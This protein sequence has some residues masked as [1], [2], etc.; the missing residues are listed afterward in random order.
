[1]IL[2]AI[3][4]LGPQSI[5]IGK[6]EVTV[7]VREKPIQLFTY[8]PKNYRAE[9]MILVFH[10]TLRN[11]D[12]YRDDAVQMAERYRALVVAPT[13]DS[14]RFPNWRY[15]RGGVMDNDFH[16]QPADTWTYGLIKPI[17]QSVLALEKRKM[18]YYLIGHSA[19]G[20]FLE[21]MSA[22]VDTG[23]ERIVAANPG[24]L[25]FPRT[26]WDFG[27]GF[28]KLPSDLANDD[29]MQRYLAQPLT[30][31]LGSGDD[32]FDEDLD[33]SEEAMREGPGRYQRGL[34]CYELAKQLAA[35]KRWKFNWRIVV[36]K[37]V[38]H[39]HAQMFNHPIAEVA[40][41]GRY[42]TIGSSN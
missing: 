16:P 24:S 42:G 34:A 30:L 8:K 5:P 7:T 31:Y 11:A 9:R 17:A 41:F 38:G 19:G 6:S 27:Y 29:A 25:I 14:E 26:D 3:L 32:H 15:H 35:E 20:Q 12:E 21:R 28:G 1:M 13:F 36:A 22:F 4:L 10:G 23:A 37:F 33:V 40:L 39:D 2:A 18:P